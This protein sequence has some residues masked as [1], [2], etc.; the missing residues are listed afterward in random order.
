MLLLTSQKSRTSSPW[1]IWDLAKNKPCS[2]GSN[3]RVEVKSYMSRL[4]VIISQDLEIQCQSNCAIWRRMWRS[5]H[6]WAKLPF[7]PRRSPQRTHRI[8]K[9][10]MVTSKRSFPVLQ[11]AGGPQRSKVCT[12]SLFWTISSTSGTKWL[13]RPKRC[14]FRCPTSSPAEIQ[15]NAGPIIKKWW[16]SMVVLKM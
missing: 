6:L 14:S 10:I 16:S 8:L 15:S 9:I 2:I 7:H 4:I 11:V 13:E 1:P 3:S 5:F 12:S